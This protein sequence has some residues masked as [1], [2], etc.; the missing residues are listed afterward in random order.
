MKTAD[1]SV[2][3]CAQAFVNGTPHHIHNAHTDGTTYTLHQTPIAWRVSA[4]NVDRTSFTLTFAG[5]YTSTTKNHLTRIADV[6]GSTARES[7]NYLWKHR[8]TFSL[9]VHVAKPEPAP[10]NP[11]YVRITNPTNVCE[12]CG[13]EVDTLTLTATGALVCHTCFNKGTHE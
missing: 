6:I 1:S 3:Q 7:V 13:D 2:A 12:D 9:V 5:H 4:P 11:A 10:L 8:E